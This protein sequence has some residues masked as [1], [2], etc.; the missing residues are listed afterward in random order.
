MTYKDIKV[1]HEAPT[2]SG[3]LGLTDNDVET[4]AAKIAN[5]RLGDFTPREKLF[6][7]SEAIQSMMADGDEK[8]AAKRLLALVLMLPGDKREEFGHVIFNT[9][10]R[11]KAIEWL[12]QNVPGY[13][14]DAL[15]SLGVFATA[16]NFVEKQEAENE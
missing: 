9:S 16:E 6:L 11:S 1:N 12:A 10:P 5:G 4:M 7:V 14:I 8:R 15:A 2:L 3:A 13:T